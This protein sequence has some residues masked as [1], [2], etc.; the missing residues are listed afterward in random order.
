MIE[1]L[2]S[3]LLVSSE[4]SIDW[5]G[6]ELIHTTPYLYIKSREM[7]AY[8]FICSLAL[9][10]LGNAVPVSLKPNDRVQ[11]TF[12]DQWVQFSS[13]LHKNT[14]LAIIDVQ[15]DFITGSLGSPRAPAILPKIYQ[16]LDDHE[17]PF[18]VA[19][20]GNLQPTYI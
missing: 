3:K 10:G 12:A 7:W 5:V 11:A 18:I 9:S 6:P 14:A 2:A 20:Q 15:N 19:S 17:W 4:Y 1:K 16:L 13:K 8:S